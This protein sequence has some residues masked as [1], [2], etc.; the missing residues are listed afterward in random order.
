VAP[1]ET[2][3]ARSGDVSIAYQVF[4]E[5]PLD[6][7]F[8]PPHVSNVELVW[9]I[10]SRAAGMRRLAEF[11]RVITFDKRGTGLS[12]RMSGAPSLEERMDDVRAVMDAVGSERAALLGVL[13][14]GPMSILFAATYP[15]RCLALALY[16][17]F[18]RAAWA[19][20]H[21][22]RPTESDFERDAR[23]YERAWGTRELI[24]PLVDSL[25]PTAQAEER[26]ALIATFGRFHRQSASPGGAAALERM[27]AEID[28]RDVLGAIQVPTTVFVPKAA[29]DPVQRDAAFLADNIPTAQ[30]VT[31][32]DGGGLAFFSG[33]LD[34][35]TAELRRFLEDAARQ[36][37]ANTE[38]S[39]ATVLFTDLIDS[40]AR[41]VEIGDQAWRDLIVS[42]NE[43]VRAEL[44]R[45]RG[46]E[47]DTAGD[48]F[49]AAFD[50]PARA[51]R[52]ACAIQVAVSELGLEMRAG[53]HTGECEQVDGKVAGVAVVTG[54]R[55]AALGSAGEVLVS[56]TVRDLVAGSGIQFDDRGMYTLKGLP[57]PRHV[58][59]VSR[60]TEPAAH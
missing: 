23:A 52:C 43:R 41:A 30:L 21:P 14:G 8:V 18:A 26:E 17:T 54:A 19:P 60:G 28:V 40:T 16:A 32:N 44:A 6:L 36:G 31:F 50:G 11:S 12:D 53:L 56:A 27:N 57:E 13:E 35:R 15:D 25:H 59:A 39:L 20:A 38:R 51:I 29:S 24:E 3:Y 49:F 37:G 33:D 34:L 1:P 47:L 7:V 22:W 48:G 4:G 58:F 2:Q 10:P 45:Y 9:E 55:I 42:H 5:G 46:R